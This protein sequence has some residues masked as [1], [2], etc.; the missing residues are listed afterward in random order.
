MSEKMQ[1]T[2][3]ATSYPKPIAK[4]HWKEDDA[5][6]ETI[7]G[8]AGLTIGRNPDND[9]A[10][11]ESGV[12]RYHCKILPQD[13]GL[14]I[15]DLESSNGTFVNGEKIAESHPMKEA[16]TIQ[17][18]KTEFKVEILEREE[19]VDIAEEPAAVPPPEVGVTRIVPAAGDLPRL[20]IS[21]GVG[22]G[23]EHPLIQDKMVIGRAS[24]N[25]KWDIDLVDRAA[26]R[27][28]AELERQGDH[29]MLNDL[30]SANGTK[31]N[32]ERIEGASVLT[33]GDAIGIGESVLIFRRKSG[34]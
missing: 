22:T 23:T 20:V 18:G 34:E 7:L 14:I 25:E 13:D 27:P 10:L 26:S 30:G 16:D 31:L 17:I 32:G 4:L 33:E 29:W 12:S 11:E 2:L 9:L 19:I 5:E 24:R 1:Q 8:I 28:H 3:M 21:S 15:V 6:K